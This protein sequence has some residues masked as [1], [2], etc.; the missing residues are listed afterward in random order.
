MSIKPG[1]TIWEAIT[2]L[3]KTIFLVLFRSLGRMLGAALIAGIIGSIGGGA[4][5]LIYGFPLVPWLIGGFV[6]AA[7]LAVVLM[8]FIANDL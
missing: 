7:V 3:F 5:S 8:V 1:I 2:D 6:V 4:V